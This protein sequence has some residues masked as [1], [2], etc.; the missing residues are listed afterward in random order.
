VVCGWDEIGAPAIPS[1]PIREIPQ[2]DPKANHSLHTY[3]CAPLTLTSDG[4]EKDQK[5]Q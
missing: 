1:H 2:W 4:A 3:A 5:E